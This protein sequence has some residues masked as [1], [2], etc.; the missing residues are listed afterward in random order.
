[1]P[2]LVRRLWIVLVPD[3]L[4]RLDHFGSRLRA[5][6]F[7]TRQGHCCSS[8][9]LLAFKA[10]INARK[11]AESRRDRNQ[12]GKNTHGAQCCDG[13]LSS[14]SITNADQL[15]SFAKVV[16]GVNLCASFKG[17]I[18]EL[19]NRE[20]QQLQLF[21]TSLSPVSF[22]W[23]GRYFDMSPAGWPSRG[24]GFLEIHLVDPIWKRSI[25]KVA[26]ELILHGLLY[27]L[28]F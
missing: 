28:L 16:G 15:F 11:N 13:D 24:T 27:S 19:P 21:C 9:G 2:L 7:Q 5:L 1:M 26:E 12:E 20:G 6:P 10:H 25:R 18:G 3:K 4:C 23:C 14:T 22:G 8:S 17:P